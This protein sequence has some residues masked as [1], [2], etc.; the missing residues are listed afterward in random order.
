MHAPVPQTARMVH[1][2]TTVPVRVYSLL[3][4]PLT[5]VAMC[6]RRLLQRMRW[7]SGQEGAGDRL[8][9]VQVRN[10]VHNIMASATTVLCGIAGTGSTWS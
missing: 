5:A 6:M 4:L 9:H 3:L 1:T 8:Q 7:W 2:G 10:H